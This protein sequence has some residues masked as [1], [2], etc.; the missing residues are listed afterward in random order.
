MTAQ[1]L[2][3]DVLMLMSEKPNSTAYDNVVIPFLNQVINE[4]YEE[5]NSL[6]LRNGKPALSKAPVVSALTDEIKF[7]NKYLYVL[8]YGLASLLLIDDGDWTKTNTFNNKYIE[9]R[10]RNNC[11]VSEEALS[12]WD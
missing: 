2:Y 4:C 12:E 3:K 8:K 7:E 1:E 5:N 10:M 6:R 11:V 9:E